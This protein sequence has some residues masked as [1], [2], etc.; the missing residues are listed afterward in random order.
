MVVFLETT[1]DVSYYASPNFEGYFLHD[2]LKMFHILI[3]SY[4]FTI[5]FDFALSFI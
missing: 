4:M 1:V 5:N 3:V 2:Y